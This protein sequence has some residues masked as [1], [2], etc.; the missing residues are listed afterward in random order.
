VMV[1]AKT[2]PNAQLQPLVRQKWGTEAFALRDRVAYMWCPNGSIESPL[3]KAVQ[4][5]VGEAGT[6][7]NIATMAKLHAMME[8]D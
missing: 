5:L 3:A 1:L 7:R 6:A 4:R 8:G 2:F